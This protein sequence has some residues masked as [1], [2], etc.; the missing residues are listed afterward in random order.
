MQVAL[1]FAGDLAV[2]WETFR[3]CRWVDLA[4]QKPGR[5]SGVCAGLDK[6]RKQF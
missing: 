6:S 1:S 4:R 5:Q 3:E 2:F